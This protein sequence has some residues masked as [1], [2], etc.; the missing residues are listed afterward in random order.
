[1]IAAKT[2]REIRWIALAYLLIL[3]LLCVPV[4]LWWPDIYTDLQKSTLFRS[5]PAEWARAIGLA[6][7]NKDEETAYRSWVALMLF[8]RSSNLVGVAAAVLIGT[9]LFARERENQTF[10]WLLSRPIGRGAILWH[11][12]WPAALCVIV[13]LFAVNASAL[14]WSDVIGQHLPPSELFL[15]TVHASSFVLFFLLVT[16]WLSVRLRVQAHVAAIVGAFAVLQIGLYLTQRIRPYTLF[17]LVDFDWY[18]PI[19]AGNR[20]AAQMF[21]PF[22]GPGFTTWLL[23]A[24]AVFYALAWR[25]LHR[26]EP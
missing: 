4:L 1:M 18:S 7:S 9:G 24:C 16:T 21:D 19:L 23:A 2:W 26:A 14:H 20:S 17:R 25:A 3:E 6:I 8:L 13:P 15:A 12:V 22:S 11:K 5:M 10:E